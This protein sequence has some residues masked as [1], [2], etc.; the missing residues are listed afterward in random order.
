MSNS[1]CTSSARESPP[2]KKKKDVSLVESGDSC[3]SCSKDVEEDGIECQWSCG[4]EHHQ[5]AG[6]TVSEYN[7]LGSS[8]SKIMFFVLCVIPKCFLC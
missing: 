7:M 3:I 8:S 6:L 1:K 5:C 4:W 2:S